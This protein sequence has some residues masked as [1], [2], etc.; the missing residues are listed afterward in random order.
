MRPSA[1]PAKLNTAQTYLQ[2]WQMTFVCD[3]SSA[4]KRFKISAEFIPASSRQSVQAARVAPAGPCFARDVP[5]SWGGV[6]QIWV[7]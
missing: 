7:P 2:S 1:W 5:R 3:L 4:E 6:R